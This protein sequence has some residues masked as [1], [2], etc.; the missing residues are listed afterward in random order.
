MDKLLELSVRLVD[1]VA[2]QLT[3]QTACEI[4]VP[5]LDPI[6][7]YKA[8]SYVVGNAGWRKNGH[9]TAESMFVLQV[10]ALLVLAIY[11]RHY[12]SEATDYHIMHVHHK[13]K[14]IEH[15]EQTWWS[16]S[17]EADREAVVFISP[18]TARE[19]QE[20]RQ[21]GRR[22]ARKPEKPPFYLYI[23]GGC[24][25]QPSFITTFVIRTKD[26]GL[27][28]ALTAAVRML[29]AQE[30][31]RVPVEVTED[32]ITGGHAGGTQGADGKDEEPVGECAFPQHPGALRGDGQARSATGAPYLPHQ[33]GAP[34]AAGAAAQPAHRLGGAR[35]ARLEPAGGGGEARGPER[36]NH[37]CGR[38]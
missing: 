35:R 19:L 29:G 32:L 12:G 3:G 5:L 31:A 6:W 1:H 27:A 17:C 38:A 8:L 24:F 14:I 4:A 16:R 33:A 7:P 20:E 22:R 26:L 28:A 25:G 15:A 10:F 18:T 36:S 23:G 37:P 34:G 21:A 2:V 13:A 30:S 11:K 9:E